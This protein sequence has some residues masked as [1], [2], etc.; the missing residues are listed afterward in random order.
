MYL[1]V[2]LT[3]LRLYIMKETLIISGNGLTAIREPLAGKKKQNKIH[4]F[5]HTSKYNT[6]GLILSIWNKSMNFQE[7]FFYNLAVPVEFKCTDNILGKRQVYLPPKGGVEVNR[8]A[9]S[10]RP[11]LYL[12]SHD[13][14]QYTWGDMI[15]VRQKPRY[16]WRQ[17]QAGAS[18]SPSLPPP[19]HPHLPLPS[20]H[21]TWNA[22]RSCLLEDVLR[23]WCLLYHE[24]FL[25][26]WLFSWASEHWLYVI[27]K[28]GFA[29]DSPLSA[30][31]MICSRWKWTLAELPMLTVPIF[32]P[33][34]GDPVVIKPF[35]CSLDVNLPKFQVPNSCLYS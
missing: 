10:S 27:L 7:E 22:L 24:H 8:W 23:Q 16:S 14:G 35:Y 30:G 25:N 18:F 33:S 2:L 20:A 13:K 32:F 9:S 11:R 29:P 5:S 34:C 6:D 31:S 26:S 19:H 21:C 12:R 17:H 1:P 3:P 28:S 15:K 4:I